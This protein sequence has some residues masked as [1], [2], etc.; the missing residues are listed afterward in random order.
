VLPAPGAATHDCAPALENGAA[1]AES[2]RAVPEGGE[3]H[4]DLRAM[5][6][7]RLALPLVPEG[8]QTIAQRFNAGLRA[9]SV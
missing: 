9:A 2:K 4:R 1:T 6:W 3:G 8:P 5:I 7:D